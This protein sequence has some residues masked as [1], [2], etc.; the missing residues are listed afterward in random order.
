MKVH[1]FLVFLFTM[2][3]FLFSGCSGSKAPSGP[4]SHS[5]ET[6]EEHAAHSD[7][8]EGKHS[9]DEGPKGGLLAVL[10]SHEYHV[11]L[12][13]DEENGV[14][15]AYLY[16]SNFHPV[17]T[18]VKELQITF[19]VGGKPAIFKLP[20]KEVNT[21]DAPAMF[22]LKDDLLSSTLTD[23]WEGDASVLVTINAVPYNQKIAKPAEKHVHK[24]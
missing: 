18:D 24:D 14:T 1:V 6:A 7:E 16:D 9:H 13:P 5:E 21:A 3:A 10:G 17:A 15:T 4:E 20:L 23:G 19:I 2:G 8:A 11:E 22:L 12:I